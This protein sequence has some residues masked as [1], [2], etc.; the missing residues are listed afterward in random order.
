MRLSTRSR[1]GLRLLYDLALYYGEGPVFLKDSARR[2]GISE[3]Y[4]SK[5]VIPLR[6]GKL[7]FSERGSR[8]G[9]SLARPPYGITVWDIV[10]VLE[11]ETAPVECVRDRKLCP[12]SDLC[13][14]RD[15]WVGLEGAIRKYLEGITL[16]SLV[17]TSQQK[18]MTYQI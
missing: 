1:Y 3:K 8:G 6:G 9:Y 4:L 7:I 10:S 12:S 14:S 15:V 5:L 13:P 2:Q 17:V 11:G 18:L 16:E